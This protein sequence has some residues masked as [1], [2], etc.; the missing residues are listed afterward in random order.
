MPSKEVIRVSVGFYGARAKEL[1]RS[2]QRSVPLLKRER[3]CCISRSMWNPLFISISGFCTFGRFL[4]FLDF[5]FTNCWATAALECSLLD[6][7]VTD[8]VDEDDVKV[9]TEDEIL[10]NGFLEDMGVRHCKGGQIMFVIFG[11]VW[12]VVDIVEGLAA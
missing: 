12:V 11:S 5:R 7:L 2:P 6:A 1:I 8:S 10:D 4:L 3:R 9:E